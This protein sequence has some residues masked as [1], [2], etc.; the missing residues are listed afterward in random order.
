MNMDIDLSVAKKYDCI[1]VGS[2]VAGLFTAL[3]L[4]Q[5]YRILILSKTDAMD[6]NSSLAQGGVAA[7]MHFTDISVHIEDTLR[8]GSAYNDKEAVYTMIEEACDRVHDML[9]LGVE[10]DRDEEGELLSTREGGHTARRVLHY[11]DY[12]GEAITSGLLKAAHKRDNIEFAQH[13]TAVDILERS[14]QAVGILAVHR[15]NKIV[16]TSRNIVLA[17]GGVGGLY[18]A[19]TNTGILTGDGIGMA[20]R[21]HI[22]LKDMEFIQFHPTAFSN[23]KRTFLI[24]EAVRGEGGYLINSSGKRFMEGLHP[25]KE[26]APRDIVAEAMFE[27]M[28]QGET[29]YL[30]VRHLEKAYLKERFPTIYSNCMEEGYDLASSPVPVRPV[31]HYIMG[32]I[33][34]DLNGNTSMK[35]VYAC[36]EVAC[37]GVH[38]ANRLASNSLLEGLVFGKRVALNLE[39]TLDKRAVFGRIQYNMEARKTVD[40]QVLRNQIKSILTKSAFII[41]K[42][43]LLE[44]GRIALKEILNDLE[45]I[46]ATSAEDVEV[47][48][49]ACV[50]EKIIAAASRRPTSLGSHIVS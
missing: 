8:A 6:S 27:Q 44:Q 33:R 22:D 49:M 40:V 1:I 48:N 2:G 14:G 28:R 38:G 16:F 17:T 31:Q 15:G 45:Y 46:P 4:N 29:L 18:T 9:R 20:I 36:G 34:T 7:A 5:S 23:Q 42:P 3:S 10:L 37:T 26:L 25:L 13:T 47:Q 11:K 21:A 50:A 24:S 32:G 41:R 12:T 19:T 43:E 30:D 39:D 35:G